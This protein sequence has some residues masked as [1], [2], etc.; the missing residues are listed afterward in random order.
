MLTR[1]QARAALQSRAHL[2]VTQRKAHCCCQEEQHTVEKRKKEDQDQKLSIWICTLSKGEA[3]LVNITLT[4]ELFNFLIPYFKSNFCY[5][6]FYI[7][8]SSQLVHS[9]VL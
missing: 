9:K 1:C 5:Q 2:C 6:N 3:I 4:L 7:M 8:Y